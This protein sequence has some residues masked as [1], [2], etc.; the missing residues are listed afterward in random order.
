MID[1]EHFLPAAF[2]TQTRAAG[3]LWLLLAAM[4]LAL[5]TDH[6]AVIGGRVSL[7]TPTFAHQ[8][9]QRL[10]AAD[11]RPVGKF[12]R[13]ELELNQLGV[14]VNSIGDPGSNDWAHF[15]VQ[16]RA[17]HVAQDQVSRS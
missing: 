2:R 10:Q 7:K 12:K 13:S 15:V 16:G 9:Q 6:F 17:G 1:I 11:A 14:G 4:P 8:I 5:R 3:F